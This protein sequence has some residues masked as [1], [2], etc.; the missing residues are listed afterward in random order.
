[1]FE[2]MK[3]KQIIL[4]GIVIAPIFF[5]GRYWYNDWK[6]IGPAYALSVSSNG[7][8]AISTTLGRKVIFWN[9]QKK[10]YKIIGRNANIYSAYFIKNTNDFMWQDLNNVVHIE[11]IFGKK[12]KNFKL[13]YPTYGEVMSSNLKN[14]IASDQRWDLYEGYGSQQKND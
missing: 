6:Y 9:I 8:Y 11:N 5:I 13:S 7:R 1:M 4:M 2:K 3:K 14:Y 12:V 10:I